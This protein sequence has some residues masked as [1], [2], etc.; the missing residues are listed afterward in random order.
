MFS[1][2]QN[3]RGWVGIQCEQS[4]FSAS[5]PWWDSDTY[6][7]VEGK[8]TKTSVILPFVFFDWRR[9]INAW[10]W[11]PTEIMSQNLDERV[12]IQSESEREINKL[13]IIKTWKYSPQR[14]R[15]GEEVNSVKKI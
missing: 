13:H 2:R 15:N 3:A 6:R 11:I 8:E 14:R 4:W 12:D 9:W 5:L 1:R 7:Q 10:M